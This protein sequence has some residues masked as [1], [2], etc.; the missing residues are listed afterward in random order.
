MIDH[1]AGRGFDQKHFVLRLHI[2][3]LDQNFDATH[4]LGQRSH[5][6]NRVGARTRSK[7]V[8]WCS[9]Q[10]AAATLALAALRGNG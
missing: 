5:A 1:G 4:A 10:L 3:Q 7:L 9:D 8:G 6:I 2:L